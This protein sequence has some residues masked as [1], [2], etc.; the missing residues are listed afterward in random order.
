M[1]YM[2]EYGSDLHGI[3]HLAGGKAAFQSSALKLAVDGRV[4]AAHESVGK[5]RRQQWR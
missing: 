2:F 4:K 1:T 3:Y 5:T